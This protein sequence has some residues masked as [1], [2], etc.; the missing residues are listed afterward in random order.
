MT[1]LVGYQKIYDT[2]AVSAFKHLID[3][4]H[5][6]VF[7]ILKYLWYNRIEILAQA[8]YFTNEPMV[9]FLLSQIIT[10]TIKIFIM[11]LANYLFIF[12]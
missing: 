12:T 4:V 11:I 10:P 3:Q 5:I 2:I 8:A 9:W 6:D 1:A 7:S